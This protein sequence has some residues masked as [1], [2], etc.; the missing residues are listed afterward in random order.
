MPIAVASDHGIPW[1]ASRSARV[2][3]GRNYMAMNGRPSLVYPAA[4]TV[5]MF[6]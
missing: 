2:P 1:P 5:T 4:Y 6:G 3:P